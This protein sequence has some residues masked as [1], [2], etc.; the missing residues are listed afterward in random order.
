ML[1]MDK[2]VPPLCSNLGCACMCIMREEALAVICG[3]K[4]EEVRN[5]WELGM[6]K[7][8]LEKV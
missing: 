5:D 7:A 4:V 2:E 1:P 6:T 3:T 8:C